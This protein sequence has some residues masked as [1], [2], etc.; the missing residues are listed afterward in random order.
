MDSANLKFRLQAHKEG[1]GHLSEDQG[2]DM[3]DLWL[4]VAWHEL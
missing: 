3:Q 2:L 4:P 1:L